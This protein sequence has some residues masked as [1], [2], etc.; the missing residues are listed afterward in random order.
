MTGGEGTC[1]LNPA[2]VLLLEFR[3]VGV[4]LTDLHQDNSSGDQSR[5]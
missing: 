4:L 3:F 1:S 5:F 2:E